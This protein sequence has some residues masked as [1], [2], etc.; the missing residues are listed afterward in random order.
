MAKESKEVKAKDE[1]EGKTE[2]NS[3]QEEGSSNVRL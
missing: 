2:S 3:I 1:K